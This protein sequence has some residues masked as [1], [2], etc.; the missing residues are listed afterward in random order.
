VES[1]DADLV[2]LAREG[3]AVAF[4]LLVERHLPTARAR[5]ARLCP[6]PDDVDDVVQEAFLQA[7]VALDRLRDPSRFAGW[8]GGIVLNICRTLRRHAPVTLVG[9]WP[10]RLHPTSTDGLPSADELDRADA[11]SRAV[12]DL[13]P[14]QRRAI[15]LFY[16]ADVP[17]SQIA[18]TTGAAKTSLHKARGRLREYITAHRP[19]LVPASRRTSMIAVRMAHA[20][21]W[22]GRQPDGNMSLSHVVVV[23]ADDD[24]HRALPIR[25][26]ARDSS[27]WR[28]LSPPE[29]PGEQDPGE[30]N[31][32]EWPERMTGRLLAAAGITVTTVSIIELGPDVIAARVEFIAPAGTRRHVT[33]RLADGLAFAVI[34]AAQ[35]QVADPLMGR[36]A[37]PVRGQ[38]LLGSFLSRQRA[39]ALTGTHRRYEP[40]N[41]A[42]T[43]DLAAWRLG[44]SF[45]REPTGTHWD[46]YSCVA[47][48]HRVI[49]AAAK[50]EPFG[51]A[52]LIQEI[53]ADDYRDQTVIF[54][55]DLRITDVAERAGLLLRVIRD[56][57]LRAA[58]AAGQNPRRDPANHF[59]PGSGARDWTR[60]EVTAH[61][62]GDGAVIGFGIYLAG[63]GRIELRNAEL[64]THPGESTEATS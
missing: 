56:G 20:E 37:E 30:Q 8:L 13:P 58:G 7:F 19:D 1:P 35:L 45:L 21:P 41:L 26:P 36:L 61:I 29:E 5:A 10:E 18:G 33:T 2:R 17:A 42:F 25:L 57:Q 32:E 22:P 14:G 51:F 44:G 23:L 40:R 59:T 27:F 11:L 48:D 43:D 3:D 38:D 55:A 49:L 15:T 47:E 12:A 60:L 16:Y 46:D 9:D 6:R 64:Q 54:R 39:A 62:P 34:T 4:R 28:L 31:P 63:R 24:G 50:P 52:F 53:F